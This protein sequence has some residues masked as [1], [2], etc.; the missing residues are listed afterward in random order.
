MQC[1]W[2][3]MASRPTIAAMQCG[4]CHLSHSQLGNFWLPEC[5][6]I[7]HFGNPNQASRVFPSMQLMDLPNF[8][9]LADLC[10]FW[11]QQYSHLPTIP[12]CCSLP[13]S[14]MA[15]PLLFACTWLQPP[16]S[17]CANPASLAICRYFVFLG[18]SCYVQHLMLPQMF[19][20]ISCHLWVF[21]Y[22][23]TSGHHV[24]YFPFFLISPHL[25]SDHLF[26][27][28]PPFPILYIL[29][30]RNKIKITLSI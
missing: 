22:S 4:H 17:T 1:Q 30:V 2:P 11:S 8:S 24:S 7:T 27:P 23:F 21:L 13:G 18:Y 3:A 14:M 5:P 12:F 29:L 10:F 20:Y 26:F 19:V 15:V 6:E 16:L 28:F 25:P 9:L